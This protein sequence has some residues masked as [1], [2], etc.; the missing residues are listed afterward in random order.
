MIIQKLEKWYGKKIISEE[1]AKNHPS[2]SVLIRAMGIESDLEVEL[3]ENIMI[4]NGDCFVLC[5]DGSC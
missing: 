2:K 4:T 5:S 1:E 3:I